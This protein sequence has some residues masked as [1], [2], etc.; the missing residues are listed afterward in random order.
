[1]GCDHSQ[2]PMISD[3]QKSCLARSFSFPSVQIEELDEETSRI[4]DSRPRRL[5]R[6]LPRVDDQSNSAAPVRRQPHPLALQAIGFRSV[7]GGRT[8]RL[9]E[10]PPPD[11]PPLTPLPLGIGRNIITLPRDTAASP[12]WPPRPWWRRHGPNRLGTPV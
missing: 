5:S 2:A 9:P 12:I 10:W 3:H 4:R 8:T 11:P 6:S 1:M 7:F